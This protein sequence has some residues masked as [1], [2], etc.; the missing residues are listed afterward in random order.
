MSVT[1]PDK[2]VKELKKSLDSLPQDFDPNISSHKEAYT[3]FGAA[4]DIDPNWFS[5]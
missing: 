5:Y 1:H 3:R 4:S 2:V